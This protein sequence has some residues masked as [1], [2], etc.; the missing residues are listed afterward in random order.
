MD[1]IQKVFNQFDKNKDGKISVSELDEVLKALGCS[2]PEEEIKRV[3]EELDVDKDGF[4]NLSEFINLCSSSF[5]TANAETELHEAFDLYDQDKNGLIS[6]EELHLVLNRLG[7]TC[8]VEKA[9]KMVASVDADHDG[10]INFEEFRKM[11]SDSKAGNE[12]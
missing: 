1:P 6:A 8:S 3:M 12:E 5:D 11:M 9:V 2:S 7:M 10:N 4:I